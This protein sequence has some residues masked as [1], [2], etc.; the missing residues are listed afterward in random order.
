MAKM[1]IFDK[2]LQKIAECWRLRLQTPFSYSELQ[3]ETFL[4]STAIYY[5][6]W[7]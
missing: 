3:L 6:I 5:N 7:S 1:L 4:A 2:K